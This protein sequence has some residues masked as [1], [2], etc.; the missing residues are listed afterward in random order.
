MLVVKKKKKKKKKKKNKKILQ[1]G[2]GA[3]DHLS[4]AC[5]LQSFAASVLVCC[6]GLVPKCCLLLVGYLTN[7]L[8]GMW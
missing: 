6:S 5:C 4:L 3:G 8:G 7:P 2:S 1:I